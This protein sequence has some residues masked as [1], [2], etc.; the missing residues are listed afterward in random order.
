MGRLVLVAAV[1]RNRV[2]GTEG[3]LPWHLPADLRR[4]KELTIGNPIIMGRTTFESIGRPLPN[5]TNIVMTR[6]A[7]FAEEHAGSPDVRVAGSAD[8]ALAIAWEIASGDDVHVIGGGEIY[9]QFIDRA[10][11]LE[12]TMVDAEPA[13]DDHFPE[14]EAAEWELVGSER[15]E[16][17]PSFEFRTLDRIS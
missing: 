2:I 11:R 5:R 16:G 9:A 17:D 8:E 15:H 14:F 6:R 13:G 7:E 4:F 12:L 1:G 10:D 3:D